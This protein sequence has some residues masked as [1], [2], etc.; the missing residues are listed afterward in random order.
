MT[1]QFTGYLAYPEHISHIGVIIIENEK[2]FVADRFASLGYICFSISDL[3]NLHP[4]LQYIYRYCEKILA[5]SIG[6]DKTIDDVLID[7][8]IYINPQSSDF[9][10]ALQIFEN[11]DE[12][13]QMQENIPIAYGENKLWEDI[14]KIIQFF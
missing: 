2:S 4:A 9:S 13:H 5:I 1:K 10:K 14:Q 12:I 8:I 7:G 11:R 3:Q 6:Q